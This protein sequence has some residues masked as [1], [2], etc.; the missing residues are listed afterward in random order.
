MAKSLFKA[1]VEVDIQGKT[2][3]ILR[4]LNDS[5][6]QLEDPRDKRIYEYGGE[7][8]RRLYT[9]G[10]L[11]FVNGHADPLKPRQPGKPYADFSDA[12][13]ASAK[14][15]RAYVLATLGQPCTRAKLTPIVLRMWRSLGGEGKLPSTDAVIRWRRKYLQAGHD[16]VAVIARKDKRGN[17]TPRYPQEVIDLVEKAIDSVYLTEERNTVQDVIDRAHSLINQE[18][19][20]RPVPLHLKKPTRTLIQRMIFDIPA[21]DR[22]VARY[23]RVIANRRFRSVL[24]NRLTHAPLQRAEIDHTILDLMAI[25]D[26]SGLPLGRPYLTVCIDDYSR[27]ILGVYIGFEPPSYLTVAHCLKHAFLPKTDLKELYPKVEGEWLA[28]G[29]MD[30]LVVDNGPEFHCTSLENACYA[31]GIE[32]HYSARKTP[33]F[34]GKIERVQGTL[35][36]EVAHGLPG[37]TFS[38]IFEKEDYDPAKHAVV[39]LST[40]KEIVHIW[41]VDVYHERVHRTLKAPPVAMW[42]SAIAEEDIYLPDDPARLDAI[43]GRSEQRRLTHKGIELDCLFY[44]SPELTTLRRQLGDVLDVEVRVDDANIGRIYVMSPDKHRIFKVPAVNLGYADGM[45]AWQHKVCRRYADQQLKSYN[46][47]GWLKAKQKIAEI[48]AGEIG[49][50]KLKTRARMARL[51]ETVRRNQQAKHSSQ[52][53]QDIPTLPAPVLTSSPQRTYQGALKPLPPELGHPAADAPAPAKHFAPIVRSRSS[54]YDGNNNA[55]SV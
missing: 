44:N 16:V 26:N 36:R 43:M 9:K 22:C 5:L 17:R 38:N 47:D 4:K 11:I 23:G 52:A 10:A 40:L 31:Q 20:L 37:T 14:V 51:K 53:P 48:V 2:L 55:T 19:K 29:V 3:V 35:N 13:W 46:V 24:K 42:K 18:N 15:R 21:Y 39:R 41:I 49:D 54:Q 50:H 12:Q 33:W 1:G 8:L 25:D 7:E 6:W 28:H 34:K 27:C 32:I 45:S 30:I